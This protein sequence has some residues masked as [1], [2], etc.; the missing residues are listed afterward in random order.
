MSL[1]LRLL[2]TAGVFIGILYVYENFFSFFSVAVFFLLSYRYFTFFL[3]MHRLLTSTALF[4]LYQTVTP[5][6][7]GDVVVYTVESNTIPL[8]GIRS[9][10]VVCER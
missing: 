9:N 2:S 8:S 3:C 5:T 7:S 4:F 10:Q 1:F 6:S